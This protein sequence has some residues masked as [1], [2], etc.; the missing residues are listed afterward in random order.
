LRK[1]IAV[2]GLVSAIILT[3]LIYPFVALLFSANPNIIEE[4]MGVREAINALVLSLEAATTSTL[5]L[6]FFGTPLA[7]L[8]ARQEFRGKGFIESIIDLPLVVPHAVVG[9][10]LLSAFGPR[11]TMG[12]LLKSF[13]LVIADSYWGIVAA[14]VFVSAPL[15]IDTVREGFASIDT[16]LEG[17]ARTLGAG[18]GKTFL[19]ISL[20]L[21][22][23]SIFTGSLLAW[24]RAMSEVGALLIIAYYPKTINIL[25]VEWFDTYGLSYA[26]A[27]TLILLSISITIFV[28]LRTLLRWRS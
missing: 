6:L 1:V 3:Y 25:I 12:E 19:T 11:A 13:G 17:V 21:A 22:A 23:R 8:L 9:I 14:F 24:A 20:P 5:I 15:L 7:Y 26:V 28:I 10:M 27:L 18:P 2:F 16:Y 4:V